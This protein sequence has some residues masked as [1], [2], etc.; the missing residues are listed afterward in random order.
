MNANV[1][2]NFDFLNKQTQK[3][4]ERVTQSLLWLH[5]RSS[6]N[7]KNVIFDLQYIDI[8]VPNNDTSSHITVRYLMHPK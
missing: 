1:S 3:N 2:T 7:F 4:K 6:K 5:W 8:F